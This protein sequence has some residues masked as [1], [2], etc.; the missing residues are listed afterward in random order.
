MK[1]EFGKK[2]VK[3]GLWMANHFGAGMIAGCVM[4]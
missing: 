1:I 4:E 2:Q 3:G